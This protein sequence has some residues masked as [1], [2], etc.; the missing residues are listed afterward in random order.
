VVDDEEP[1]RRRLVRLLGGVPGVEIAGEAEDGEH[2]LQ[3]VRALAPDVLFLDVRMPGLDGVTLAQQHEDLPPIIFVTAHDAHAVSAFELNA[4]DYLLKP[5]RPERL[6]KAVDRVRQRRPEPRAVGRALEAVAPPL[7]RVLSSSRGLIR[8]F[9][10]REITRFWATDKYTL[11]RGDGQEQLTEEPL[12]ALETRLQPLGFLR[13]HRA[14]LVR[15]SAVKALHGA[16]GFH[17]VELTD[18][19]LARVSRRALAEVRRA[20]GLR[21]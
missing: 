10:A 8:F 17:Q 7:T 20:L 4:V 16:D 15:V 2:A 1:A 14:E 3:Q 19:Q 12:A 11:F 21:D 6:A 13:V 18:G 5:V 9:D